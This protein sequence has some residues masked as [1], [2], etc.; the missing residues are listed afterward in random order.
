[1]QPSL[2]WCS[3]K[4]PIGKDQLMQKKTKI[5]RKQNHDKAVR[6]NDRKIRT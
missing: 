4:E 5:K 1:M 2:I 6:G 3:T